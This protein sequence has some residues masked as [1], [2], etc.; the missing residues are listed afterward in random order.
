MLYRRA[1]KHTLF[2]VVAIVDHRDLPSKTSPAGAGLDFTAE[3]GELVVEHVLGQGEIRNS[4]GG[5]AGEAVLSSAK[6]RQSPNA[7]VG[8]PEGGGLVGG[9]EVIIGS[10]L[11]LDALDDEVVV[12]FI[13]RQTPVV[14]Q[15]TPEMR[16]LVPEVA[17]AFCRKLGRQDAGDP[18]RLIALV[19]RYEV[20]GEGAR[21]RENVVTSLDLERRVGCHCSVDAGEPREEGDRP[22]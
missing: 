5:R 2:V 12:R 9:H 15:S 21:R 14:D 19:E 6:S 13:A 3:A 17:A 8:V 20:V 18:P 10:T 4:T 11:E 1:G 7:L 16:G 22:D